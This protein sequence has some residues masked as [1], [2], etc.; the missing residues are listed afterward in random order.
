MIN[1]DV[2]TVI[3]IITYIFMFFASL[4]FG[5]FITSFYFRIPRGIPL[6]G[7]T[8]PPMCSK[9][10]VKL[11]YPD[12]GPLYHHIFRGKSCKVCGSEIPKEYFFMELFSAITIMTAFII[13]GMSDKSVFMVFTI[14]SLILCLTINAKHGRIPEKALWILFVTTI[15]YTMFSLKYQPDILFLFI[16]N[17]VVG[18]LASGVLCKILKKQQPEGYIGVMALLGLLHSPIVSVCLFGGT[19][20]ALFWSQ[21]FKKDIAVKHFMTFLLASSIVIVITDISFPLLTLK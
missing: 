8:H 12:Y 13:H 1:A 2:L 21:L 16:T 7:R 19:L 6:N 9:C 5:N 15:A 3:K 11:K 17:A 20:F 10:G 14:I 4:W 18:F